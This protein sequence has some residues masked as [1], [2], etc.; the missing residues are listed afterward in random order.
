MGHLS[1]RFTT[2]Y[3][4]IA[5]AAVTTAAY[6]K[7]HPEQANARQ[8]RYQKAHPEVGLAYRQA[9]KE[10]LDLQRKAW[11]QANPDMVRA[12]V[13]KWHA[14]HPE[15]VKNWRKANPEAYRAQ[16]QTRHAREASAEGK[17]TAADLKERLKQQKGRCAYC[18]VSIKTT[19]TVDHIIALS[20]GGS[21]WPHNIQLLCLKCN[22]SKQDA[23][24][25]EFAR[26]LGRLV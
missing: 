2:S 24:P 19:W 7:A 20:Q 14:S 17:H 23:D 16:V 21:N 11:K 12:N 8:K 10:R 3:N 26:R 9:N 22:T 13:R 6:A 25:I 18:G 15:V 4:C 5:C 1:E